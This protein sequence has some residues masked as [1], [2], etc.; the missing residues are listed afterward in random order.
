MSTEKLFATVLREC[1]DAK[2]TGVLYA[3]VI[4]KSDYLIRFYFNGGEIY[5]ICFG[6]VKNW[7]LLDIL[8]CYDLKSK[9]FFEGQRARHPS[10]NPPP[11]EE[12]IRAIRNTNKT[13][14]TDDEGLAG[15]GWY[16]TGSA[17]R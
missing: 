11:T 10:Q 12:V 4:Q 8:D 15:R 3:S 14:N 16:V 5:H 7:E 9:V 2:K 1:C 13:I 6:P 17:T